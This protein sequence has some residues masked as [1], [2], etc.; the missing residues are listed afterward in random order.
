MI[1]RTRT[2]WAVL[3]AC[4]AF[5]T[6]CGADENTAGGDDREQ[7]R[8]VI[9]ELGA[10]ARA[11]NGA[12]VCDELF[13]ENLRISITRASQRSCAQEVQR[14]IAGPNTR[15]RLEDLNVKGDQ[16]T[17]LT[18]DQQGRRSALLMQLEGGRWR[19]ARIGTPD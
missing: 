3:I 6:G 7:I 9:E 2:T 8:Q 5:A 10:A 16:A 18:I 19:I 13:T 4:A 15:Y 1:V 14:N 11:G 17:G 12:R